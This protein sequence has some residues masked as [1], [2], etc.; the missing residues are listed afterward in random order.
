MGILR[1][2]RQLVENSVNRHLYGPVEN[3]ISL[4]DTMDMDVLECTLNLLAALVWKMSH[5]LRLTRAHGDAALNAKLCTLAQGWGG[6]EEGLGLVACSSVAAARQGDVAPLP[7]IGD[8]VRFE[9]YRSAVDGDKAQPASERRVKIHFPLPHDCGHL[10]EIGSELCS[11]HDVPQTLRF[12]LRTR[13]RMAACFRELH[14]RQQCVRIRLLSLALLVQASPSADM[15]QSLF[16]NEPDIQGDLVDLVRDLESV[17]ED[18]RTVALRALT[19]LVSDRSRHTNALN[20]S[21]AAS[22][23]VVP[24]LVRN[25]IGALTDG[26]K[27]ASA[28]L[29]Y[30]HALLGLVLALLRSH[31]STP[32]AS[33]L[34]NSGIIPALLPIFKHKEPRHRELVNASLY[35]LEAFVDYSNNAASTFRELGGVDAVLDRLHYEILLA[36]LSLPT[37]AS[38]DKAATG[39]LSHSHRSLVRLLLRIATHLLHSQAMAGRLRTIVEGELPAV[40]KRV[41]EHPKIYGGAIFAFAT[42]LM[43]DIVHHDTN[44]LAALQGAKLPEAVMNAISD[45]LVASP[46]AINCIPNALSALCLSPQ[47]LEAITERQCVSLFFQ[48]MGSNLKHL[49]GDTPAMLGVGIDELL[50]HVPSLRNAGAEAC[51][52]MLQ[53]VYESTLIE[54]K[55]VEAVDSAAELGA[56]AKDEHARQTV[57]NIISVSQSVP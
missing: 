19:A 11:R 45:G 42:S 34:S 43:S 38:S 56:D 27:D 44:C 47:C 28:T 5:N 30:E 23:R 48:V 36:D 57:E 7:P 13:V 1:V 14:L 54:P 2:S 41:I 55:R 20:V 4:L 9:F 17:P 46:E 22:Q 29:Q 40:L 53:R 3:L 26:S 12:S 10:N 52:S 25:A 18:V 50:R 49:N 32:G 51:V 21:G 33:V 15:L 37:D 31:A 39:V 16:H 8:A 24:M 35:I 6:K